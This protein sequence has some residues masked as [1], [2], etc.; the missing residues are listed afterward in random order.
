MS[1]MGVIPSTVST[2]AGT[3][4]ARAG[5]AAAKVMSENFILIEL[6]EMLR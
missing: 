3:A 5:T 6:N 1:K 4:A 2:E